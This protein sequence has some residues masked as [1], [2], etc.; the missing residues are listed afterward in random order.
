ML[1]LSP[2]GQ[3]RLESAVTLDAHVGG[4]ESNTAVALARL[5]LRVA[6]WSRLPDNGIGRRIENDL[7]RWGVETSQV[8]WDSALS[9]RAGLFF[10][11]FGGPPRGTEV[12]YDRAHSSAS[13][14]TVEDVKEDLIARSRLLHLSGITP[15]LST[16]CAEAVATAITFAH[17][18]QVRISLDVNYRARLWS[19]EEARR[20]LEPLLAQVDLLFCSQNDAKIVFQVAESGTKAG[21][22]VFQ[23]REAPQTTQGNP[24][25][26][27]TARVL[28]QRYG[29][30]T[31]IVTCGEQGVAACD[32]R[33]EYALP[34]QTL[35]VYDD[36]QYR[37][38]SGDAFNAGAL[39]GY[40]Q[41]DLLLGLEYG[42]AMAA[43]KRTLR[44]DMLIATRREIEAARSGERATLRR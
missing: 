24:A 32:S 19:P 9:A 2:P 4:S 23:P 27:A 33:G 1:R 21:Q 11:E 17:R 10:V 8:I 40:L 36:P 41:G 38:G 29:V 5:Q 30:E 43:L 28:Q 34:A 39:L 42:V 15:A 20:G 16:D 26:I 37:V 12:L 22:D 7:R 13:Q 25:G 6:W 35:P 14:I 31:V 18:H 44:G 3:D